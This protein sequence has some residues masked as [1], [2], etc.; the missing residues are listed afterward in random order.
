MKLFPLH[1]TLLLLFSASFSAFSQTFSESRAVQAY[2]TTDESAETM[3]LNWDTTA[4][5]VEFKI[6]RRSLGTTT[7]GAAIATLAANQTNY[8]D[9]TIDKGTVY[10]YAVE[11]VTNT[12]DRFVSGNIKGYSYLAASINAPATHQR[13]T[14]WVLATKLIHDSLPNEIATLID[15][16]IA[17]GWNVYSEVINPTATHVDVKTFIKSKHST[18]GCDAV[19][20]LGHVP[21]PYSGVYCEDDDYLYPPDGH[22]ETDPNSHCGA[23]P[24]DAFYGDLTGV[25]TDND[26][27]T[28]AKRPENN[29]AIG[30]GKYDQHRIPGEVTVGVGRVDMSNLPLFGVS[31]VALTKRYLDKVHA[32][33]MGTVTLENMGVIENNFTGFDEGFSSGALRDFHAILGKNAVVQ[34]DLLGASRDKDY[35]LSYVCGGGS[36]T[37][38]SGFGTSDSFTTANTAA[39]NHMFGS[40]FGDWDIENN[41]MRSSLATERLGYS[42]IWSGRPKWATHTLAMGETMADITKRSQNNFLN[43]DG[44]FYQNGTH[45]ALL[46]DPSLRIHAMKPAKNISLTASEDRNQTTIAW[47]ASEETDVVGYFVYRSHR[48]TGKYVPL[49]DA[50]IAATSFV[51]S[52]PYDGTNHYMVRAAKKQVTGSGSYTNLSLGIRAEINE[53]QGEIA[54]QQLLQLAS[55]KVYPTLV[56]TSITIEQELPKETSYLIYNTMGHL[57]SQGN[58]ATKQTTAEV[59]NLAS[60]AYFIKTAGGTARFIKR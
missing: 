40:F 43:Y 22:N 29:N 56:T 5:T 2:V 39:F 48:E 17:D 8:T 20:L 32:F 10:E 42:V 4:N 26:S 30:D 13:G 51:D 45:L 33:K 41:L 21:V 18:P 11:R 47:D 49:N 57:V 34:D 36:Y 38:C 37:S 23:W 14:L 58:F 31:E 53:M 35:L 9:N 50:P 27:T 55:I 15:D 44:N 6:Y 12:N 54:S 7:W 46:G 60:G 19:Y 1:I 52:M 59:S 3:T 28:L 25:W 16:L 24:A